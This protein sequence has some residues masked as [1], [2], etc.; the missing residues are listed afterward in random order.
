MAETYAVLDKDVRLCVRNAFQNL[1][2]PVRLVNKALQGKFN[3]AATELE[4][5]VINSTLG[6]AG[7]ADPAEREFGIKKVDEDFG[8]TLGV[9]GLGEIFYINWP[10]LGPSN[11]RD[12]VG[13]AVDLFLDPINYL[14]AG[15]S[16]AAY[17]LSAGK[18]VNDVSLSLGDYE[19]FVDTA[20]DPYVAVRDAYYQYR[21]GKIEDQSRNGK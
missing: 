10:V 15:D 1:L 7:L 12:S 20:M 9:Y 14:T 18:R 17:G 11:V 3:G 16:S 19:L 13:Y 6:I 8:Q 21:K 2:T 4:R 5:F